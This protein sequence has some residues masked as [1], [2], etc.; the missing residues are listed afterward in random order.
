MR[1]KC[2]FPGRSCPKRKGMEIKGSGILQHL[3][4]G[5]YERACDTYACHPNK[6][7]AKAQKMKSSF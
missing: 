2:K 3:V 7:N 6:S 4:P 1:E 5:Y